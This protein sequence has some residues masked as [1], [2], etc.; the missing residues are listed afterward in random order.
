MIRKTMQTVATVEHEDFEQNSPAF[1]HQERSRWGLGRG[2][3]SGAELPINHRIP[4]VQCI[5]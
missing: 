2:S 5:F 4:A 3:L 1:P